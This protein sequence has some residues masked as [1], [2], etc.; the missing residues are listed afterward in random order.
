MNILG[1]NIKDINICIEHRIHREVLALL[2]LTLGQQ[3][4]NFNYFTKLFNENLL[5][6]NV[7][8]FKTFL[9]NTEL[10]NFT[11]NITS[12]N[13]NI[14]YTL[15][16][17]PENNNIE[18]LQFNQMLF[19]N[20]D[21][22]V[23]SINKWLPLIENNAKELYN[24]FKNTNFYLQLINDI[25][26]KFGIGSS[27]FNNNLIQLWK[28]FQQKWIA[29]KENTKQWLQWKNNN[30]N[31]VK[32]IIYKYCKQL[33]LFYP[34][35]RAGISDYSIITIL[36]PQLFENQGISV[37]DIR[38]VDSE[39]IHHTQQKQHENI[40][41]NGGVNACPIEDLLIGEVKIHLTNNL[42]VVMEILDSFNETEDVDDE[43]E[44]DNEENDGRNDPEV[45]FIEEIQHSQI[46]N[47][48]QDA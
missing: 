1:I 2:E 28:N 27:L 9:N 33:S 5:F 38:N 4:E 43:N 6:N 12:I 44:E 35:F 24:N 47:N 36:L 48:T 7:K 25:E 41:R 20:I 18:K 13:C 3:E 42:N 21:I 31:D 23:L 14:N 40:G 17:D 26:I 22:I 34:T 8:T 15:K 45:E 37:F 11:K 46:Y 16:S 19:K 30:Y 39:G 32:N 29:Q 10:E